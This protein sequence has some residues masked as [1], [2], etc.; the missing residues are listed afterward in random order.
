MTASSLEVI[1]SESVRLVGGS[2]VCS[3]SV[4]VKSDQ[5]WAPVCEDGF[6]SEAEKVVCREFGCGPPVLIRWSFV[7]E[8]KP[9]LSKKFQCK[10]NESRLQDC[11]SSTRNNCKP[12]SGISCTN[13]HD[14]RLVGGESL[15]AG[16]LEG[17]H[18]GEWRPL[19]DLRYFW[20]PQHS[21]EVCEQLGCGSVI[22]TVEH[23]LQ[24]SQHV[25]ELSSDCHDSRIDSSFCKSWH[26]SGSTISMTVTC[27]ET[28][29]LVGGPKRCS[30]RLEVKSG[31]S[32][33]SVCESSF[34]PE[35]AQVTCSELG[36][37]FLLEF[38]SRD[39]SN[40]LQ[41]TEHTPS[42]VF[43]CGGKEKHLLDCSTDTLNA[44]E[45]ECGMWRT[46]MTCIERPVK[47]FITIYTPQHVFD[48]DPQLFKGQRFAI[49]CS[50]S[51]VLKILSIRLKFR[52]GS[53]HPTEWTQPAVDGT[54]RFFFPAAED[55][56][57]GTYQCDYNYDFNSDVF[58][59]PKTL[60]LTVKELHDVRLVDGFSRCA[61]RLEVKHQKEWRPVSYR[62]SWSLKEAAVVCSQLS[63]GSA[64]STSKVDNSTEFLPA[65]RFYSDCDGSEHALMDC[66]TVMEWSSSSTVEVVC[67]DILLQP[68]I[69]FYSVLPKSDDQE[70]QLIIGYSFTINC[71]T[72]PQYPGGHFSLIFNSLNQTHSQT[73]PAV[74]HSALF[75]FTA[76]EESQGNYSCVYHNFIFNHNYSS[77]SQSLSITVTD[78]I[79]VML[80]DGVIREDYSSPCAGKLLVNYK[81]ELR[82]LSAESTVWD[83][84][85]ASMVCRQLGCG[86]AVSTK[87]VNLLNKEIMWRFFSDC[88]GSESA[89]MDC[90]AAKQWLSS[91]YVEV[92]CTGQQGTPGK[93]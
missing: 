22:S 55:A 10:G 48:E 79:D 62:H 69:T 70:V 31:P 15:C 58:S 63:C 82:L 72:Q 64:V 23:H 7:R 51:T 77:Q 50:T 20:K 36:C 24:K 60:Y 54:A 89:L 53:D 90:G 78:F 84:K 26:A 76:A 18:D 21:A 34:T 81:G 46:Y 91:S 6:D 32:W 29:R 41:N 92:A 42:P 28:V 88:D 33:A 59:E 66:G 13:P 19:S 67:A 4:E 1:C 17:K 3:G 80:D 40:L 49:S 45:Q 9:V 52:V 35:D 93:K 16:T 75:T 27:A 11:A 12:A 83:L 87:S 68:N 43:N 39:Y 61:G 25:W 14:V 37:G 56:H 5:G 71:S 8:V 38:Y 30:G 74:N 85:H 2:R 44:T 65:W 57:R 73:Q 86:A 47:P